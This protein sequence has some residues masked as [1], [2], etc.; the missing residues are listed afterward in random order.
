MRKPS[1]FSFDNIKSFIQQLKA[2]EFTILLSLLIVLLGLWGFLELT[3]EVLEGGTKSYDEWI[4]SLMQS[5]ESASHRMNEAMRDITAL[6]GTAVLVIILI[7]VSGFM[8]LQKNYRFALLTLLTSGLGVL[9][10]IL[11]KN[12]LQRERPDFLPKLVEVSTHSYPSGHTMMSAVVYLTL[13]AIVAFQQEQKRTKFYSIFMGLL[14]TFLV[15]ISRIYLGAHYPSD[16]FAGWA[17]GLAWAASCWLI[18]KWAGWIDA[19]EPEK[20]K[21]GE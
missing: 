9:L 18:V 19:L 16:V 17:V 8:A 15:G 2:E 21:L 1:S 20:D 14:L 4:M 3:D 11:L 6:G 10:T 5:S 7:A 12:L 13:A